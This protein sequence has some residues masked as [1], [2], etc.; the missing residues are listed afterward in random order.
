[1]T[2]APPIDAATRQG[3]DIAEIFARHGD[4]ARKTY[5]FAAEQLR[6]LE[7]IIACRTSA[8]G[9]HL[10]ACDTCPHERPSYNSCHN[11]HCPKCQFAK[12]AQWLAL[13]SAR[14][15]PVRHCHIVFTLPGRL[16]PCA[17]SQPEVYYNTLFEAASET[18]AAFGR[19]TKWLGGQLGITAILHTW[20]RDLNYHPHVHCVV[21]CGG[22][23]KD[24]K[25]WIKPKH[26]ERY[27]FP[28]K[29]LAHVFRGIFLNKIR[30]RH[31]AA[32][33][34]DGLA[35]DQHFAQ[36][37]HQ[38]FQQ[39]WNVYAK[40]PFGTPRH[41][42]NYLGQY[43][44]RVAISNQRIISVT[45][46]AVVFKTKHGNSKALKPAD[47]IG[48][49]LNHVLP[50]GFVKIR[51]YGLYSPGNVKDRLEVARKLLPPSPPEPVPTTTIDPKTGKL[52]AVDVRTLLTLL[53]GND[54]SLCPICKQGIMRPIKVIART[55]GPP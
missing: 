17:R 26:G 42:F 1:M 10:N 28:Q 27:L 53:T 23:S 24:G 48:R 43:T 38:L 12:Q 15:L 47:F 18:L 32:R 33:A 30:R 45:D 34:K 3:P 2:H 50:S 19:D 25:T 7:D 22:L 46:Q 9:G 8:L 14:V 49:F 55:R 29:A 6:T 51:H 40:A 35:P 16:R 20:T 52:R 4:A 41:I 44:H 21:T 11:R 13:R 39:K 5:S 37:I 54:P 36:L 31:A